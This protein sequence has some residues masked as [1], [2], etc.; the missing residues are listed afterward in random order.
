MTKRSSGASAPS[1]QVSE[2]IVSKPVSA[3]LAS[4]SSF[5]N[6]YARGQCTWYVASRRPIPS[7]WGNANN[8]YRSALAAG[9]PVG[10][11]PAIGAIAQTSTGAF[12]HVALV[13]DI[14]TDG[15]QVYVSEMNYQG[16]WV[17]STRWAN[18]SSFRY[19]Y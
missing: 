1:P 7:G 14:S 3:N 15:S 16:L 17:R 10:N 9:W 4:T 8:W 19:I 11:L 12:G 5:T 6:N 18:S 13:E 2:T